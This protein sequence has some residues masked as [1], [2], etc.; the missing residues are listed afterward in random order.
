MSTTQ[1]NAQTGTQFAAQVLTPNLYL[2]SGELT[3]H[4]IHISYTTSG[5]TGKPQLT[6]QDA[7]NP[8]LSFTGDQ[9][10]RIDSPD[11]GTIVSVTIRPTV[12]AGSTSLSLIIPLA[13]LFSPQEVLPIKTDAIITVHRTPL[14][15]PVGQLEL[16]TVVRLSGTA[17]HVLFAAPTRN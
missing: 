16:Y 3:G 15:P 13:N 6:Y 12:D 8:P 17:R 7:F 10:R 2:L 1:A 11:L 14:L 9:I 5:V 4:E